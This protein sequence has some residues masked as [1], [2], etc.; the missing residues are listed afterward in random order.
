MSTVFSPLA[1]GLLVSACVSLAV[2]AVRSVGGLVFLELASYDWCLKL[3][4][5]FEGPDPR[6][7]LVAVTE[8]D[9]RQQRRWPL[10]DAAVAETIKLLIQYRP[11]AIG[12]DIYRDM[13]VPPGREEL[14]TLL[15]QH[16]HIVTVMLFG[17]TRL[18][19]VPP[20][21][22]LLGTNQVGFNDLPIDSDGVVRRGLLFLD[23][24]ETIVYSLA[25]RLALLYLEREGIAPKPDRSDPQLLRLGPT[26]LR[27]LEADDGPYVGMDAKGYQILLD[28]HSPR[29][30]VPSVSLTS[31]LSGQVDEALFRDKVVLI[32]V[33]AQSV[34]DLFHLPVPLG[35]DPDRPTYGLFIHAHIASQLLRFAM[36]GQQPL[37]F[38][39]ESWAAVWTVMWGV[40]GAGFGLRIR[41]PWRYAL[42]SAAGLVA[43][44]TI[45]YSIYLLGWWVPIAPPGLNLLI[46]AGLVTAYMSYQEREQR[47]ILMQLFSRHVSPEMLDAIWK[48]RD[49]FLDGRRPRAKH[50]IA[51]V[52]FLD[53]KGY[54]SVAEK[55]HPETLMGWLNTYIET[56]ADVVIHHKG[57]IDDYAGDGLKANFGIPFTQT[58]DTDIVQHAVNAVRCALSMNRELDRL[59]TRLR[60]EQLPTVGMRI[61]IYTGPV[62][63]GSIGSAQRLKYTTIGDTVNTAARIESLVLD[64]E[65][66]VPT[67][68]IC[69]I[70]IGESTF[71]Y[72]E[73]QFR[74]ESVGHMILKGKER[75]INV[76]RVMSDLIAEPP[77]MTRE[78]EI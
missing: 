49:E 60:R 25:L 12:L 63:A 4:R 53:L 46:S 17:D 56:M 32:G 55:L 39:A 54:T 14:N 62:V 48:Q 30:F 72:V 42:L 16:R 37:R 8:D 27:P 52:L 44:G 34:P 24:G 13:N 2:L 76:Y 1:I 67:S 64:R 43:L 41:T 59:N 21:P 77:A 65:E 71:Q 22:A 61:G 20:P 74:I 6:I 40:I 31:L 5:A 73:R 23:D 26:T 75:P 69:R 29:Y 36:E 70:L 9:I 28:F 3:G 15:M 18:T 11:R 78:V 68:S 58:V 35:S 51:T 10:T 66:S 47:T 38:L 19:S 50:M 45:G 7:V 57:V 33:T